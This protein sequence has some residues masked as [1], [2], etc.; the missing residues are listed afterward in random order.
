[1]VRGR[2]AGPHFVERDATYMGVHCNRASLFSVLDGILIAELVS[3]KVGRDSGGVGD[4]IEKN[5]TSTASK[6]RAGRVQF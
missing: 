2:R 3:Q 1:M 4:S 5:V 6:A